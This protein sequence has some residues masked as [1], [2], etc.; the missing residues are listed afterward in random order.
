MI[1]PVNSGLTKRERGR[2]DRLKDRCAVLR[3]RVQDGTNHPP[4]VIEWVMELSALEWAIKFIESHAD[5]TCIT[6]D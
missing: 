4:Y 1:A 6:N 3:A 2:L 5:S